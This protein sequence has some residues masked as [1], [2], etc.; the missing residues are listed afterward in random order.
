MIS[1][2][3]KSEIITMDS[4]TFRPTPKISTLF[5]SRVKETCIFHINMSFSLWP[6][7]TLYVHQIY[8]LVSRSPLYQTRSSMPAQ[9]IVTPAHFSFNPHKEQ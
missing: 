9:L 1:I 2:G 8:L 3:L 6:F 7:S 5:S 4:P